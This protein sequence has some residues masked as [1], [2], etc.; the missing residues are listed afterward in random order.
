MGGYGSGRWRWHSKKTTVEEC[1]QL[2]VSRWR[3]EG[4][5]VPYHVWHGG[6]SWRD[7]HTDKERA[8]IGVQVAT[9]ADA[10]Q[11][12]LRYT[13]T[14]PGGEPQQLDYVAPLV[15]TRPRFG[16]LRWWFQC[17]NR[18]CGRRVSKLYMPP[19]ERYFLCRHCYDLAYTSSQEHDK[20]RDRF[21]RLDYD[22]LAAM[23]HGEGDARATMRA[24]S[25]LLDR[26]RRGGEWGR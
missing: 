14:P 23:L 19:G 4:L 25:E 7:P 2:D 9:G 16:G 18:D 24:A 22:T 15:T 20:G 26:A 12:V 21:R 10:G 6:W 17:P 8:S 3:R 11:V 1:R 13:V 5:I